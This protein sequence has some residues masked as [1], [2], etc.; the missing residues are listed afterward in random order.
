LS[1]RRRVSG[2]AKPM[3]KLCGQHGYDR[4]GSRALFRHSPRPV[5]VYLYYISRQSCDGCRDQT[6][7]TLSCRCRA[8]RRRWRRAICRPECLVEDLRVASAHVNVSVL[9]RSFDTLKQRWPTRSPSRRAF[10]VGQRAAR[11][12]SE[13]WPALPFVGEASITGSRP[14]ARAQGGAA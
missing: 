2:T 4:F 5:W 3:R 14:S 9:Y 6:S 7:I 10:P 12:L 11:S 13:R 8:T 1:G